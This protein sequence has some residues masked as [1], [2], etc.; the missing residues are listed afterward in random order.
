MTRALD[1]DAWAEIPG[2]YTFAEVGSTNADTCWLVT[3]DQGGTLGT[4]AITITAFGIGVAG[5]F[6]VAGAG[7][8]STGN[9]VD[10]N[11]GT[12]ITI[13][14]DSVALTGQALA[15]HNLTTA[16]DK[17]PYATGSAT[18]AT[19]DLTS[20]ARTLIGQ[21]TVA[22]MRTTGLGLGTMAV[23]DASTVA[24][25]GGTINGVTLDGGVY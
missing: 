15:F 7:L 17:L 5:A 25:T 6:N 4:T 3:A 24:I 22:A 9:T 2:A 18:F 10:V 20:V 14:S 13:T 23:Q 21:T 11:P 12:G 8:T 1:M 16:A 19:T